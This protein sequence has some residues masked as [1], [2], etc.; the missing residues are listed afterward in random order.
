MASFED[1]FEGIRLNTLKWLYGTH[2]AS[3]K[4]VC[5]EQEIKKWNWS[6]QI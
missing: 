6:E 2:F 5:V 4:M 1:L 3:K